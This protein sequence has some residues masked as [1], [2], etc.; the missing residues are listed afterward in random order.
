MEPDEEDCHRTAQKMKP[1]YRL[2][3]LTVLVIYFIIDQGVRSADEI[4]SSKS[5]SFGRW[6]SG[7]DNPK[8][9]MLVEVTNGY[10][11]AV[12]QACYLIET[13]DDHHQGSDLA[14][15]LFLSRQDPVG[16]A[17]DSTN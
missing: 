16:V 4:V 7:H 2:F 6:K 3:F 10:A 11:R 1:N 8:Q 9:N 15:E 14:E 12:M 13:I 5:G 17:Y